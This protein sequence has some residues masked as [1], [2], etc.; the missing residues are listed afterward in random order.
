MASSGETCGGSGEGLFVKYDRHK[1]KVA[2][3]LCVV[4][5]QTEF[6]SQGGGTGNPL[7]HAIKV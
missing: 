3:P 5:I 2:L 7:S 6:D 1:I 4:A